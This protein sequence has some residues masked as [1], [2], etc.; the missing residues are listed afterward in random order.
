VRDIFESGA[1]GTEASRIVFGRDGMI[2][3]SISAP[4]SGPEV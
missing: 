1:T 4:G 3:M 2:Y